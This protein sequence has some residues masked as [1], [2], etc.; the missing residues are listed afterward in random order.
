L[1]HILSELQRF[2]GLD[3][4]IL[5]GIGEPLLHPE[6]DE[7]FEYIRNHVPKTTRLELFT[8]GIL[9]DKHVDACL[10]YLDEVVIGVNFSTRKLYHQYAGVDQFETVFR[11]TMEFLTTKGDNK[12]D[13]HVQLLQTRMNQ[14]S[15]QSFQQ[16]ITPF[17]HENDKFITS[18]LVNFGGQLDITPYAIPN[19]REI[20]SVRCYPCWQLWHHLYFGADGDVYPCCLGT[21]ALHSGGITLG[22][23][24]KE[25]DLVKMIANG[26]LDKLKHYQLTDQ[27]IQIPICHTCNIWKRFGN[28]FLHLHKQWR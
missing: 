21:P 1:K 25:S 5:A 7:M 27:T 4:L 26:K 24:H 2:R 9:L 12:P 6:I 11:N 19:S 10:R 13:V 18:G 15:L 22:N 23:L 14:P 16:A 28:V 3:I 8:N 20:T 17:L